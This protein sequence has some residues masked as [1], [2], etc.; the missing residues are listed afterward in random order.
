MYLKRTSVSFL[1]DFFEKNF[2]FPLDKLIFNKYKRYIS[3]S[4]LSN[5]KQSPLFD[6][7]DP[8]ESGSKN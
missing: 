5:Q 4:D 2:I 3:N 7:E 8:F 1:R 6:F